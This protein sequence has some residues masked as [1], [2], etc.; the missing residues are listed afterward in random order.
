MRVQA[1]KWLF[2]SMHIF[3]V[4]WSGFTSYHAGSLLINANLEIS[5]VPF[6]GTYGL[7]GNSNIF[8]SFYSDVIMVQQV[9]KLVLFMVRGLPSRKH[10]WTLLQMMCLVGFYQQSSQEHMLPEDLGIG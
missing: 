3:A 9:A 7:V 2:P 10:R 8:F 5:R 1:L 6:H 4:C